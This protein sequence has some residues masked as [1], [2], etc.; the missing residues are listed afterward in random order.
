MKHTRQILITLLAAFLACTA[1]RAQVSGGRIVTVDMN[2]LFNEYYKTKASSEKLKQQADTYNREQDQLLAQFRKLSDELAKLQEDAE[3]PEYTEEV[4][5][6]K[7]K[8][9]RDKLEEVKA[10]ETEIQNYRRTHTELLQ[11]ATQRMRAGI[12]KEIQEVIAKE[13]RDL[14]YLY[15]FDKSGH[16]LNGVPAILYVQDAL[17]ITDDILK[18]LNKG[19]PKPSGAEQSSPGT[20]PAKPAPK[21]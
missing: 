6:Q 5:A 2:R 12:V 18:V 8:L 17:D 20:E 3:K 15:V 10:K 9:V 19:A 4:K 16:T 11:Q 14:G 13:A 21:K 7:R 1:G